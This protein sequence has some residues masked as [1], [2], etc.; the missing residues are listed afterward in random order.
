M[1]TTAELESRIE[2]LEHELTL[3]RTVVNNLPVAI[4]AKDTQSRFIFANNAI[5][6]S[7]G[8]DSSV[9]MIGKTDFAIH[10]EKLAQS[11]YEQEQELLREQ[12]PILN[13][14]ERVVH[15]DG[16]EHWYLTTKI[17]VVND[18]QL[19]G[20]V[21][22]GQDITQRKEWEKLE[23]ERDILRQMIDYLPDSMFVKDAEGRYIMGNSRQVYL[24]GKDTVEDLIGFRDIDLYPEHGDFYYQAEMELIHSGDPIINREEIVIDPG[25]GKDMNF[26]VTKIPIKDDNGE[27]IGIVGIGRDVTEWKELQKSQEQQLKLIEQQQQALL[28]LSAPIIPITDD[29]II[30]PL[31]GGIDGDRARIIMR[32]LLEGISQYDAKSVIVDLTGVP[33][34]DSEVAGYMH[35]SIQAIKLKGARPII[36]G[37]TE[38]IAETIVD[39]GIDWSGIETWRDLQSGLGRILKT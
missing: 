14:E 37:I 27:P 9:E 30:M 7:S 18:G 5:A 36:T 39:L 35:R 10:P 21:G 38:E 17:P 19:I 22:I 23:R 6:L 16:S 29:I 12:Q 11:Y 24:S 13:K 4:Y 34:V 2:K 25:T 31:I 8:F 1:P 15:A 32:S 20:L 3:L 33:M 28:D 26:L